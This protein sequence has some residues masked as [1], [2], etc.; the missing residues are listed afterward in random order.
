MTSHVEALTHFSHLRPSLFVADECL[1]LEVNNQTVSVRHGDHQTP[2]VRCPH[3]RLIWDLLLLFEEVFIEVQE[4]TDDR[5]G[6]AL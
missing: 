5:G 6:K 2:S 3:N 4:G 1:V